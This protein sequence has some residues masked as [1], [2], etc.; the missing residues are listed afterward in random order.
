MG[1]Y[2]IAFVGVLYL[3]VAIDQFF[4]SNIPNSIVY[5]GFAISNIGLFALAK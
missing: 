1:A 2:L 3:L 4:K 5:L